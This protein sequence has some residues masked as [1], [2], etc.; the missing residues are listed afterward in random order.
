MSLPA[1]GKFFLLLLST[2]AVL[3]I[4]FGFQVYEDAAIPPWILRQKCLSCYQKDLFLQE[5]PPERLLTQWLYL[6]LVGHWQWVFVLHAAASLL[7]LA[8]LWRVAYALTHDPDTS[9][10]S[11]W[12]TLPL[13]Y[14]QHWGS[15]E[16]YYPH[17][18][19]SLLAKACGIWVWAFLLEKQGVAASGMLLATALL[20]PSVGWQVG[21]FALPLLLSLPPRVRLWYGGAFVLVLLQAA[22]IAQQSAPPPPLQPLWEKIFIGFRLFMHFDP[23]HF[24]KSSHLLFVGLWA[25]GLYLTHKAQSPLRWVFWAFGLAIAAYVLNFYT[26]RWP[27][28]LYSQLPRATV[29]LKPLAISVIVAY[30]VQKGGK[31]QLPT[32]GVIAFAVLTSWAAFRL[33]RHPQAGRDFLQAFRWK[34]S[35]AYQLGSWIQQNLP[36]SILL[37]GPPTPEAEKVQFFSQRSSYFWIGPIFHFRDPVTYRQRCL[38]LYGVDPVEGP[39]AWKALPTAGTAYFLHRV[40]TMPESLRAWG[41]THVIGPASACLP[42][43]RLWS[44]ETLALWALPEK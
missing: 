40:Q 25:S 16:L 1:K 5:V 12:V 10:I 27:L 18:Q 37:A 28:L 14:Y 3:L 29:W 44:G 24:K 9:W 20:H 22:W 11:V 23:A 21:A 39:K 34:E 2:Y 38:Q 7:L 19:P 42:Y 8:G 4:C 35:E 36:D 33:A 13:L 32:S 26:V 17:V 31:L 41:I 6:P 15:N 30:L 43:P